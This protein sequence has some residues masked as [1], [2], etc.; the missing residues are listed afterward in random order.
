MSDKK[1]SQKYSRTATVT[2]SGTWVVASSM[3]QEL[4]WAL[5]FC[6]R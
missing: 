1:F 6:V 4:A 2:A 5:C 3:T